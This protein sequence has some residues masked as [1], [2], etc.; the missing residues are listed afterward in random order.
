MKQ[1]QSWTRVGASIARIYAWRRL[2]SS[3]LVLTY[4]LGRNYKILPKKELH[5]NLQ[6]DRFV[7]FLWGLPV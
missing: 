7:V 2:C 5:R 3:F 6:V 1:V 4:F